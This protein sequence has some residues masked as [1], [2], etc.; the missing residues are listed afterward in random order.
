MVVAKSKPNYKKLDIS[1]R[2]QLLCLTA[3]SL[4]QFLLT[5]TCGARH[6]H[7]KGKF[8]CIINI[9]S[10]EK[11]KYRKTDI[12]PFASNRISPAESKNDAY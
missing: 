4:A 8:P 11:R 10:F 7:S 5:S 6:F 1:T 3:S 2:S 12:L 9:A